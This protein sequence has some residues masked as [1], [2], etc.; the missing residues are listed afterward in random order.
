M[1]T[2]YQ[3]CNITS[4]GLG[5]QMIQLGRLYGSISSLKDDLSA[6]SGTSS[7]ELGEES[8]TGKADT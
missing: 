7:D 3:S 2:G 6:K 8:V 5:L 1:K 4:S